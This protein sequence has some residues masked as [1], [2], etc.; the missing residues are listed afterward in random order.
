VLERH[1]QRPGRPARASVSAE[2]D[3]PLDVTASDARTWP[4]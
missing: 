4:R 3:L 1:R 2:S